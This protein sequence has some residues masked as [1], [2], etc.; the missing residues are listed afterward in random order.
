MSTGE[1]SLVIPLAVPTGNHYKKPAFINGKLRVFLTP[2]ARAFYDA[3]AILSRGQS[4]APTDDTERRKARYSVIVDVYL[5]P[6]QH[7]D[8]DNAWKCSLDALTRAG[9]I[10]ND[11]AVDGATSNCIIH[12]NDRENPRTEYKVR[13]I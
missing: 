1:M 3:V 6:R 11:S 9:I 13:R 7:M 4:V 2:E 8:F 5:G 10:H 12:G